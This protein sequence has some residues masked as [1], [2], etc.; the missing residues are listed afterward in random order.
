MIDSSKA[1]G[2]PTECRDYLS[3]DS[4]AI[5]VGQV[6]V[7]S[8]NTGLL[9]VHET[10]RLDVSVRTIDHGQHHEAVVH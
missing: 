7:M 2:R 9:I 8:S 3:A 4:P 5:S 1:V 6:A 10:L